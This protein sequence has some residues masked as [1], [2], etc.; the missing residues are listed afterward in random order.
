MSNHVAIAIGLA[1]GLL[2]GVTAA[3]TGSDAL[4]R[5]AESVAPVG[6]AFVNLV[7]M[8]V[9]PLVVTTLF[10][11]VAS[12]A[13]P[14]RLSRLGAVTLAFFWITSFLGIAIGMLVMRFAL[15]MA[16]V[17]TQLA[18][19]EETTRQLPTVVDFL[20]GLIPSNPFA[21]AANGE[22]LPLIVFTV[23]FS[24]AA[25]ALPPQQKQSLMT[26]ADATTTALIRLV[27]WILWTAPVGVFALAAPVAARS[28]LA[29]LGSLAVFV[30]A[31]AV[32]LVIFVGVSLIPLAKLLGRVPV[33][34]FLRA[35]V[36]P[37]AI[38]LSTT[39]S[40]AAL[41]AMLEAAQ[42][43]LKVSQAVSGLVLSLGASINR[44]GSALF[45]GAAVVFLAALYGVPMNTPQ[46]YGAAILA[47]F[48][49]SLTVAGVPSASLVTLAPALDAV[50]VP[51]GGIA[52]LFGIDRIP[53]MLRT[54]TNIT[55]HM[56]AATVVEQ[57][58]KRSGVEAGGAPA[59]PH[60]HPD[61]PTNR[62]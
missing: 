50:G 43:E 53:D 60:F 56:S 11:G 18:P 26:V 34:V 30:A 44:S 57:F 22:L 16:P 12:L 45:Q 33:P 54:A 25:G 40:P 15:W 29:I 5:A 10:T 46:I 39:S 32:G 38:G 20:V 51:I 19:A 4:T 27:H 35:C 21:A 61:T 48:L 23:A 58:A 7:R 14:K 17:A 36:S 6:T 9:I 41:P 42:V 55:G 28:G 49:V 1:A 52:V 13:N 37:W 59:S 31:V 8:V 47:T 24:A 2:F 62:E 3:L